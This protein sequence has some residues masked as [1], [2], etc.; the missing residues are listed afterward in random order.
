MRRCVTSTVW[1]GLLALLIGAEGSPEGWLGSPSSQSPRE[2]PAVLKADEHRVGGLIE[3]VAFADLDGKPGRLSDFRGH[4]V[5]VCLTSVTC[6]VAR[7][8]APV[9]ADLEK[10][11]RDRGVTF[12]FVNPN[13]GQSAEAMRAARQ[14]AGA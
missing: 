10:Q 7:K 4:P 3:D 12:L 13:A 8:Y 1:V 9:L 11:Y 6:P 5:V 14:A 2:G